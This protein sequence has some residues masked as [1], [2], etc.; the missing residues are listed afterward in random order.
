MTQTPARYR[1]RRSRG[2]R[3]GAD[4]K[5]DRSRPFPERESGW[6]HAR[7]MWRV[8]ARARAGGQCLGLYLISL[9]NVSSL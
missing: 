4:K 3:E 5:G 9:I 6:I 2:G 1:S 7:H 8:Y